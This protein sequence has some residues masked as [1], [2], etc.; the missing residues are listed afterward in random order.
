MESKIPT[1]KIRRALF[2][3]D[4]SPTTLGSAYGCLNLVS[5]KSESPSQGNLPFFS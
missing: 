2:L 3:E 4:S 1:G 5:P